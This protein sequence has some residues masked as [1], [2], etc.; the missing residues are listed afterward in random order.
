MQTL[1]DA[2]QLVRVRHVEASA[3]VAKKINR[4]ASKSRLAA[5]RNLRAVFF[6]AELPGVAGKMRNQLPEQGR[7]TTHQQ[8]GL[9]VDLHHP[10]RLGLL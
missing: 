3:V 10:L 6:G 9:D 1:K 8:R 5:H 7:I 2:K 4:L